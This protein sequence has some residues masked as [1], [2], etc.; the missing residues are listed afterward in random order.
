MIKRQFIRVAKENEVGY[1]KPCTWAFWRSLIVCLCVFSIVGHW[2]EIPY[3]IFMEHFFAIVSSDYAVWA[4][5]LYVP[6]WVYGIGAVAMTLIIEPF[7]EAIILRCKTIRGALLETFFFATVLSMVLELG[8]GL[9]INQPDATG[10][11]PFWDNSHLPFN[12]LGQAWLVNDIM[13]G[14]VAVLYVWVLYP[15]I[16][17]GFKRLSHRGANIAFVLVLIGFGLCCVASYGSDWG[18]W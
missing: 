9:L 1:F 7:K 3:C 5:P 16:C 15:L 13:I 18:L 6:Y 17:E 12:I 2:L 11:Y 14:L 10:T 4:D 8:I